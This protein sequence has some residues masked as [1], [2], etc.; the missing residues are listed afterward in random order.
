MF[1]ISIT[2][3]SIKEQP[4]ATCYFTLYL[5]WATKVLRHLAVKFDFQAAW[6]HPPISP[7]I[8]DFPIY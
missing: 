4:I 6:K 3:D 8:A 1:K 7:N 2:K 5:Q